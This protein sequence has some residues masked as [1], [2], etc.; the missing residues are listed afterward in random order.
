MALQMVKNDNKWYGMES[1]AT[2]QHFRAPNVSEWRQMLTHGAEWYK[3]VSNRAS[4]H[5]VWNRLET[6]ITKWCQQLLNGI[7]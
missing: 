1:N 7:E 3:M 6:N 5:S 2:K 4:K